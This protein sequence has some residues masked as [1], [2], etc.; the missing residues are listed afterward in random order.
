MHFRS[1]QVHFTRSLSDRA[2]R[3]KFNVEPC[4]KRKFHRGRRV[5]EVWVLGGIETETKNY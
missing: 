1:G 5:D 4:G 3:L 2:R